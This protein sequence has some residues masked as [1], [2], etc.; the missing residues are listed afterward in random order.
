MG[1]SDRLLNATVHH[2]PLSW[3]V[4]FIRC[5]YHKHT[6]A[7]SACQEERRA[8]VFRTM[9]PLKCVPR[10]DRS[11]I[12]DPIFSRMS[13]TVSKSA[14]SSSAAAT[15]TP[16]KAWKS[17]ERKCNRS[18]RKCSREI[19]LPR[20]RFRGRGRRIRVNHRRGRR[21]GYPRRSRM[22]RFTPKQFLFKITYNGDKDNS[23]R[24]V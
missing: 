23:G 1:R 11:E 2:Q 13:T 21:R 8:R 5:R 12:V 3:Q 19:D 18:Y 4:G 7:N 14:S 15:S 20:R 10:P 24:L 17:I 22:R 6:K 16:R 9:E